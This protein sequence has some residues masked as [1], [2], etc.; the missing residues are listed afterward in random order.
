[1]ASCTRIPQER[2]REARLRQLA[3]ENPLSERDTAK[4]A[5]DFEV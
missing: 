4:A 2:D 1:M 3:L 5:A